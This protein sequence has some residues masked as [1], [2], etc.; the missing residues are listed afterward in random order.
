[1]I[2]KIICTSST[3]NT[4]QLSP[5][6]LIYI[7]LKPVKTKQNASSERKV[8]GKKLQHKKVSFLYIFLSTVLGVFTTH[9]HF[10]FTLDP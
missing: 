4:K 3:H 6:L 8:R 7:Q 9:P 1:M 5:N 10:S 2:S